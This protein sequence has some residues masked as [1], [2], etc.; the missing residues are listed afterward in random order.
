M[1]K[2]S[3]VVLRGI[4]KV[5]ISSIFFDKLFNKSIKCLEPAGKVQGVLGS[6]CTKISPFD[7]NY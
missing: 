5:E 2:N 7:S 3:E 1:V 6:R 4:P